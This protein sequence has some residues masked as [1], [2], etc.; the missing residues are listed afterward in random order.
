MRSQLENERGKQFLSNQDMNPGLMELT[1]SVLPMSYAD[2]FI[3]FVAK[4][5]SG[6]QFHKLI[7]AL[8]QNICALCSTFEK[9]FTGTK[10]QR[11]AQKIGVGCKTA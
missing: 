5:Y 4:K 3:Y 11:K 2:P 10:V 7:H 1:A 6:G 9:L 8:H